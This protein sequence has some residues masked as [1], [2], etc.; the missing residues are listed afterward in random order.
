M[1]T[2]DLPSLW[3]IKEGDDCRSRVFGLRSLLGRQ[4]ND[5]AV[6][7]FNEMQDYKCAYKD[8]E[9]EGVTLLLTSKCETDDFEGFGG[10]RSE[11]NWKP[12]ELTSLILSKMKETAEAHLGSLVKDAVIPVPAEF[13][14]SQRLATREAGLLAGFNV[15]GILRE[16]VAAAIAYGL[17]KKSSVGNILVFD[18][19]NGALEVTILS[20]ENNILRLKSSAVE[21]IKEEGVEAKRVEETTWDFTVSLQ[22]KF[23]SAFE[24]GMTKDR[25]EGAAARI[26]TQG[27][28]DPVQRAITEAKADQASITDIVIVGAMA[29]IP[30][31]VTMEMLQDFF[32]VSQ[33]H[34]SI[35]PEEVLATGAAI[36]AAR[37]TADKL[38]KDRL[39]DQLAQGKQE[40]FSPS[41]FPS[42]K[43]KKLAN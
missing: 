1:T 25:I 13:T 42:Q 16:P 7:K 30:V 15:V 9:T 36:V 26:F 8:N 40:D 12:E 17:D 2:S 37:L 33:L 43:K 19:G 29:R 21:E 31:S 11:Q 20:C 22:N 6:E 5:P 39:G 10:Y 23:K 24:E 38:V 27:F 14:T 3:F 28:L 18:Q 41:H 32:P 35:N 34:S 4:H